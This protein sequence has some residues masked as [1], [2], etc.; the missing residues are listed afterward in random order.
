MGKKRRGPT[1]DELLARPW[2]YYCERDFD[3]LKIL[4]LH[5]KAKHFKC[6]RCHRKL[7]TAGGLS[8]HMSQVH[9]EQ[10]TEIENALPNRSGLDVEIF[11]M[12]GVP[13]D[14]LQA[15]NQRVATQY[16]QSEAERQAVTG[17]P[18]SGSGGSGPAHKK[19][20]LEDLS[21]IKARLAAH[22]AKRAEGATGGSS[23]EM[24][25]VGTGQS[26]STPTNS[27]RRSSK[28][29]L[30]NHTL[31]LMG[32]PPIPAASPYSLASPVYP[33]LS[34]AAVSPYAPPSAGTPAAYVAAPPGAGPYP[35]PGYPS[36]VYP[37]QPTTL[38]SGSPSGSY[39]LPTVPTL[40][41]NNQAR[42]GSLPALSGLPQRPSFAAP[43]LNMQ[44]MQQM[45]MGHPAPSSTSPEHANGD[46]TQAPSHVASS[47]DELISSAAK[48]A[49]ASEKPTKKEK[50]KNIRM[51]YSDENISPEEKMAKL[52]RYAFSRQAF[53]Q[54]TA[55]GE[56]P[57]SIVV[58][59]IRD[60]DTVVDPAH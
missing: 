45:H 19:P 11:G 33:A 6:E 41:P 15:H 12:E 18:P 55:L 27:N 46:A 58:G 16:H 54:E 43:A 24:T 10:L 30:R 59:T 23:R 28:H 7:N 39:P 35:P 3:D 25:P 47:V 48:E 29:Q 53:Q 21:D 22:R 56:V 17:N 40:D 20:K 2:C 52:P 36:H 49:A 26:A 9:K 1:L 42:P 44:Q 14:V 32:P 8:V 57:G 51:V 5:Q 38:P 60:Q 37:A 4:T 13:E 34:P 50:S 31:S